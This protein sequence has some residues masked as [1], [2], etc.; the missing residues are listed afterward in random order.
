MTE[1]TLKSTTAAALLGWQTLLTFPYT[2]LVSR[3]HFAISAL[4]VTP[5]CA[6]FSAR[7]LSTVAL[8]CTR[9][10]ASAHSRSTSLPQC[11]S[12]PTSYLQGT[13]SKPSTPHN[14]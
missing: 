13:N 6:K 10:L 8:P 12:T 1:A 7:H 3:L 11:S 9:F 2:Q 14:S 5:V 4:A